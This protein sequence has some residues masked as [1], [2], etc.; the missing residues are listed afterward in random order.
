[1]KTAIIV[2]D[3]Q[4]A[5][6]ELKYLLSFN[7]N[8]NVVNTFTNSII[9]YKYISN[10]SIDILFLDIQMPM[11]SGLEFAKDLIKHNDSPKIIFIT[12][13]D[14]YA[15]DA[16]EVNAIDYLLKP[17]NKDRLEQAL[18]KIFGQN[19]YENNDKIDSL[20]KQKNGNNF[21]SLYKNGIFVPVRYENIIYCKSDDGDVTIYTKSNF[22]SYPNTLFALKKILST[23]CFFQCH[24]SY[25]IN[26]QHIEKIEPTERTFLL[27]M[28]HKEELIPVSRSNV[29]NFKNIMSIY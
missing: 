5:I 24:R 7:K 8:I 23:S 15:L 27:K 22:F 6:D 9:A 11:K 16:F 13:Y 1:M 18:E 10:H 3:E 4:P 20:F 25:I 14:S 21:I 26:I 28:D 12:A 29:N 19:T 17:T 2:D